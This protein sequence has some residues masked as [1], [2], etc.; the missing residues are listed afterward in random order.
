[1]TDFYW[2]LSSGFSKVVLQNWDSVVNIY[3]VVNQG[4]PNENIVENHLT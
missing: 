2:L 4:Q 1:M 3:T